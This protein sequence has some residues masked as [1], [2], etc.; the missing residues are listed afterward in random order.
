MEEGLSI[1]NALEYGGYPQII[2]D[3][4]IMHRT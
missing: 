4:F 2:H 1:I 3:I